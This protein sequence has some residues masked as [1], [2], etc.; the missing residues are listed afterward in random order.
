MYIILIAS[1]SVTIN[2]LRK[3]FSVWI[4]VARLSF[5]KFAFSLECFSVLVCRK[6]M[7]TDFLEVT[8]EADAAR[9]R[10]LVVRVVKTYSSPS[11]QFTGP[12]RGTS[13]TLRRSQSPIP[14][15]PST[16][17]LWTVNKSRSAQGLLC[18]P[19]I[20]CPHPLHILTL[21]SLRK[22]I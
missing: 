12:P 14:L 11:S 6:K 8:H 10:N 18:W 2:L 4:T 3:E 17:T 21:S 16:R 15:S 20:I 7:P 1:A 22:T 19:F 13:K 5:P 9:C